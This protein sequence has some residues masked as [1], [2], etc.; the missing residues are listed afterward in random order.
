MENADRYDDPAVDPRASGPGSGLGVQEGDRAARTDAK[1]AQN[2]ARGLQSDS[3]QS[4]AA[5]AT[6]TAGTAALPPARAR[7]TPRLASPLASPPSRARA[8]RGG[9]GGVGGASSGNNANNEQLVAEGQPF[10]SSRGQT[11]AGGR[12]P[13]DRP[14]VE[15]QFN[16]NNA[17][18]Y[19][20]PSVDPRATGP[21][22]GFGLSE[23]Q[24]ARQTDARMAGQG[25]QR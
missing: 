3:A 10:D 21:G 4:Q 22:S 11:G 23:G 24:Q 13:Y 8:S 5:S 16:M 7:A 19:D 6:G 12:D 17:D 14:P 2:A 15:G 20:D 18:R 9:V 1:I 25:Q